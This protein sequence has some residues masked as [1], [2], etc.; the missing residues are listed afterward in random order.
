M[1]QPTRA[2]LIE[3]YAG[4]IIRHFA[5][6]DVH[7]NVADDD[8]MQ[9]DED[10]D[11]LMVGQSWDFGNFDGVRVRFPS[12]TPLAD[13]RRAVKKIYEETNETWIGEAQPT[14]PAASDYFLPHESLAREAIQEAAFRI[15]AS[16]LRARAQEWIATATDEQVIRFYRETQRGEPPAFETF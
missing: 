11:C 6:I 4:K 13:V 12:G 3:D 9:S 10:G 16:A 5:Q 14:D 2:D 15:N 1:K 8:V 7:M